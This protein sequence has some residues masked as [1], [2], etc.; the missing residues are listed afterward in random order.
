VVDFTDPAAAREIAYAD[1][2]RLSENLTLGGD[3]SSY[4]YNGYIYEG[5]IKRGLLVWQLV[6]DPDDPGDDGAVADAQT[7]PHLNPQTQ[8]STIA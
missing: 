4:W 6:D 2:E 5:D 3:W 1:P 8:E 7:L